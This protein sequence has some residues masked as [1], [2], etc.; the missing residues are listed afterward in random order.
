MKNLILIL[1]ILIGLTI[2]VSAQNDVNPLT[3]EEAEHLSKTTNG[4]QVYP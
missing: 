1:G 3:E 4:S 2:G